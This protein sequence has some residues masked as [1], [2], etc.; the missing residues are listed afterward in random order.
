MHR[1]GVLKLVEVCA[2]VAVVKFASG[3]ISNMHRKKHL[4]SSI[5]NLNYKYKLKVYILNFLVFSLWQTF[6]YCVFTSKHDPFF[7]NLFE[8]FLKPY[9]VE[10]YRP[11]HKGDLFSVNAAMRNVE[12]KVN[13]ILFSFFR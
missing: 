11:L 4:L 3:K 6:D 13:P 7:S 2:S 5:T 12:F 1:A 8:V 9:F 10:S